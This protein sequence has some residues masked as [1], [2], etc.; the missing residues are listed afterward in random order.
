MGLTI[1]SPT[2][3]L[4]LYQP[5]SEESP[6]AASRASVLGVAK[7]RVP[8]SKRNPVPFPGKWFNCNLL[9]DLVIPEATLS[10]CKVF[11]LLKKKAFW[12]PLKLWV[13]KHYIF[14]SFLPCIVALTLSIFKSITNWQ[15]VS[16]NQPDHLFSLKSL[17]YIHFS[18]FC[19]VYF[20]IFSP[21]T[22]LVILSS[23]HES[24]LQCF[25]LTK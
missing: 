25:L 24:C 9:L 4:Y 21:L 16:K 3:P 1:W 14:K 18:D 15:L 5:E 13:Q 8:D 10:L 19:K 6:K 23:F 12:E 7:Q 20:L 2:L 22:V 11:S 17:K